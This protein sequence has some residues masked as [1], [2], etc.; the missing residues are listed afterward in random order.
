MIAASLITPRKRGAHSQRTCQAAD[1]VS[2]LSWLHPL[3]HWRD[4]VTALAPSAWVGEMCTAIR[5]EA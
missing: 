1:V 4:L 3:E 5:R 2:R